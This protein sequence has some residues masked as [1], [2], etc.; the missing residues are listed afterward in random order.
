MKKKCCI[1]MNADGLEQRASEFSAKDI[2][3][4]VQD[5][6]DASLLKLSK[7]KW[8]KQIEV[9]RDNAVCFLATHG[10]FGENGSLQKLLEVKKIIHTHSPAIVCGILLNKHLSKL[11]YESL[12]IKTPPWYFGG[13]VYGRK[14]SNKQI[15]I[16]VKKPL[17]GGSKIGISK[18]NKIDEKASDLYLYEEYVDGY[19]Q[20]SVG[21]LGS[22][23]N[24]LPLTPYA[25]KRCLFNAGK[26]YINDIKIN[27]AVV[28]ICKNW[29]KQIHISLGCRGITKT[30]F[31]L[32]KDNTVWAIETDAIPGLSKDNAVSIGAKKSGLSFKELINIIIEDAYVE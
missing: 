6:Y 17:F 23:K 25:R 2:F 9:I 20:I 13:N 29:A 31:L 32:S 18:V 11:I 21:V 7:N 1:L 22:G 8:I 10:D 5:V 26:L 3:G 4:A 12:G 28:K 14:S 15:T 30:D 27:K 16:W 19:I 24:S